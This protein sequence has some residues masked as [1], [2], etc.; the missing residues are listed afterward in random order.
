MAK[1]AQL[2]QENIKVDFIDVNLG[3]PIDLIYKQG[4]GSG[5]L[6]RERILINTLNSMSHV[7]DL[8]LTA[9]MRTGVYKDQYVAH[10]F[11]PRFVESGVSLISVCK[12]VS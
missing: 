5:L 6:R 4:A 1:C 2:L 8:P 3:C 11:V 9:K 10:T 12:L 7:L